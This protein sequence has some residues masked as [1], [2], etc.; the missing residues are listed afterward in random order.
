MKRRLFL[1]SSVSSALVAPALAHANPYQHEARATDRIFYDA[2]FAHARVIA[3]RLAGHIADNRALTPV[4]GDLTAPW[5]GELRAAA[6][7]GALRLRG[8]TT[9]S[10][11]FCLKTLLQPYSVTAA[12]I[13]RAGRD[14][15][16]WEITT[17]VTTKDGMV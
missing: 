14:L 7:Q 8:V 4:N 3:N 11:Y 17:G 9:E 6:S 12:H 16:A 5:V 15:H 13:E 2:R 10:F 1:Q